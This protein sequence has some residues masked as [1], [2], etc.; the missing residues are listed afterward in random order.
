MADEILSAQMSQNSQIKFS[1]VTQVL[2]AQAL[3]HYTAT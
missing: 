3:G 2:C 1:C